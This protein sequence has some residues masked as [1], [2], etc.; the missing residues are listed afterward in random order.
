[1][2]IGF[3]IANSF[4]NPRIWSVGMC[5]IAVVMLLVALS[6]PDSLVTDDS[7]IVKTAQATAG[8]DDAAIEQVPRAFPELTTETSN[9]HTREVALECPRTELQLESED[10]DVQEGSE[11]LFMRYVQQAKLADMNCNKELSSSLVIKAQALL[12]GVGVE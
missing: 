4:S 3:S 11:H 9:V 7:Q 8:P 12:F 5:S 2:P 1:M 6:Q 10:V